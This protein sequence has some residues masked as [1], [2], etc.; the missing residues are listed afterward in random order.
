M[1]CKGYGTKRQADEVV[2]D[3][4]RCP[5]Y[6]SS[7]FDIDQLKKN[8]YDFIESYKKT[9]PKYWPTHIPVDTPS[10][11]G[12][13]PIERIFTHLNLYEDDVT[14]FSSM[15][16]PVSILHPLEIPIVSRA[17][18]SRANWFSADFEKQYVEWF[19]GTL[20]ERKKHIDLDG[21]K[22]V[23]YLSM[24]VPVYAVYPRGI[25][26]HYGQKLVWENEDAV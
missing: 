7:M 12:D 26:V 17:Q 25:F 9:D 24:W 18:K 5:W 14:R 10:T 22:Y 2:L 23:Y 11:V 19:L 13:E 20:T 15:T 21:R 3:T 8:Q 16:G 6:P 1:H 4:G